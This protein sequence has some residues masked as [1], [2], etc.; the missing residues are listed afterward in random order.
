MKEQK[1]MC[2]SCLHYHAY[3]LRGSR[4]FCKQEKGYCLYHKKMVDEQERCEEWSNGML[5]KRV[6][7]RSISEQLAEMSHKLTAIEQAL[8]GD[9][10]VNE[11]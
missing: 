5:S 11:M 7:K 8:N 2:W 6:F 3:Y 4:H 9:I 10:N 1:Q